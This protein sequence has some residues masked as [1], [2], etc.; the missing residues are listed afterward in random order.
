MSTQ[1]TL[2]QILSARWHTEEKQKNWKPE[3]ENRRKRR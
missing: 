3:I 1:V 2:Q